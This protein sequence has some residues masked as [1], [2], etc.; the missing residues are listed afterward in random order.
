MKVAPKAIYALF[1]QNTSI[2]ILNSSFLINIQN[3]DIILKKSKIES[4]Y[5]IL[6]NEEISIAGSSDGV[7][8]VKLLSIHCRWPY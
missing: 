6:S 3:P 5:E 4:V 8:R 1:A 7:N 2:V